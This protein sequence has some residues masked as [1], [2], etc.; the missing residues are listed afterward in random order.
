MNLKTATRLAH[1]LLR[2]KGPL[3]SLR[4]FKRTFT[5]SAVGSDGV[6]RCPYPD[7]E[8]K[9]TPLPHYMLDSFAKYGD[10]VAMV[11]FP[12]GQEWT[13][14]QLT[15]AVTRVAS[16]LSKSGIKQGDAV[17]LFSPNNPEFLI[18]FLAVN[19]CGA[20]ASALNPLYTASELAHAV[21]EANSKLIITI[22][23]LMPVVSKARENLP[24]VKGVI[25]FGNAEGCRPFTDL[26]ND[27]GTAFPEN[28]DI[29]PK[30]D[31]AAL[32]FSSGTTG[33]PKGV[34]LSHHNIVSNIQQMGCTS[35][36]ELVPEDVVLGVLPFFHIYGKTVVLL[37]H[38]FRGIKIV[39]MPRF[40]PES[41]LS[42]TQNQRVSYL[43]L[44]PP[45]VL[46]LA[47]HP[48]VAKYDFSRVK[49]M[50]TAAAPV[51]IDIALEAKDKMKN[52]DLVVRQG[53]GM[54]ESSPLTHCNPPQAN[55]VK[56]SSVGHPVPNTFSKVTDISTGEALGPNQ[57][58]EICSK[59]P[60]IMVGYL[61]NPQATA[62]TVD[63][64]GWLRSGDLGYYDEDGFFYVTDRLKELIKYKG[65]QVAPAELEALLLRHPEV[66]DAAVIGIPDDRY[67]E[68]PR[69]YIRRKTNSQISEGEIMQY[70]KGQVATYKELTGGIEFKDEIP[71]SAAGKILR[72]LLK[73][74]YMANHA[75]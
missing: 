24:Q 19:A 23:Q 20:I 75:K 14:G 30:K 16:A 71:K 57:E 48:L 40:E 3:S 34:M 37:T 9:D 70:V 61:N 74:E 5:V 58:G 60:Q 26:L 4:S 11:D 8:L 13:F 6:V 38:L 15:T 46:F 27:D 54:T 32:P 29:S 64:E 62:E 65:Y 49:Q 10:K 59:G 67:G 53:Y 66:E 51:S 41:F 50:L 69:A 39:T 36:V 42:A 22:P 31:L 68:L 12:T 45:I 55:K 43:Y 7:V 56:V 72:R 47:K 2:S 21:K 1:I 44:V 52:P 18:A 28:I 17:T 63:A 73:D 33:L 35:V 25:T